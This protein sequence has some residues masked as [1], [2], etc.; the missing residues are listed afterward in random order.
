MSRSDVRLVSNKSPRLET[1]VRPVDD[2][3]PAE[4]AVNPTRVRWSTRLKVAA[5]TSIVLGYAAL[6]HYSNSAPNAKGLGVAVSLGPILLIGAVLL[7]RW[8]R[9]FVESLIAAAFTGMLIFRY[10]SFLE[11]N[12]QWM[13]LAMQFGAYGLIA[14]GFGRSLFA[15]RE[16]LCT[17]LAARLHGALTPAEVT[18]T[19]HATVAWSVFYALIAAAILILFFIVS[20]RV[21]SLFVNFATF[22]LITI[23]G[24]ADHAI[25]RQLLPRRPGNVI[26]AALRQLL[27]G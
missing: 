21:W 15:G 12:Y 5:I 10:R 19:R 6:S 9:Q 23:M 26:L 16:P 24:I 25:R 13:D 11:V 17:H 7:W 2:V 18:Y 20:L 27:I 22:G 1:A 14:L 4:T 8:T 3:W